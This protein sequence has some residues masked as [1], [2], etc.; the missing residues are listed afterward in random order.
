MR[1]S[2]P[3]VA[4]LAAVFLASV[5]ATGA[6]TDVEVAKLVIPSVHMIDMGDSYG[7]GSVIES[8]INADGTFTVIVLTAKHV[9]VSDDGEE[10]APYMLGVR[11]KVIAAH[12]ERDVALCQ[13]QFDYNLPTIPGIR[14][15]QIEPGEELFGFGY[16][17]S[18]QMWVTHGIASDL[19]RGG[20]A[21]P[22]D[23]GG[24]TVDDHGFLVGVTVAIDR[25]GWD[26]LA[27]HHTYLEP[28]TTMTDWLQLHADIMPLLRY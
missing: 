27:M 7:S 15:S 3:V 23:S 6:P 26:G 17:L 9:V 12:G 24:A 19:D 28:L 5:I 10:T 8:S 18:Q 25:S 20:F 13:F 11:G 14:M 21:A 4:S 1:K 2:A 16:G 22:G